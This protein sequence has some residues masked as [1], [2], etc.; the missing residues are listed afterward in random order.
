MQKTRAIEGKVY[1][2]MCATPAG[3]GLNWRERTSETQMRV[4]GN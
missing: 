4:N 2:K 3:M 1:E